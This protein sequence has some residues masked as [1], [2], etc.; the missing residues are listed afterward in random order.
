MKRNFSELML[1]DVMEMAEQ[2]NLI[3]WAID[4]PPLEPSATLTENLRRLEAFDLGNTE[5]A[6]LC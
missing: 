1:Q 5:A 6:K 2:E 4:A 3:K